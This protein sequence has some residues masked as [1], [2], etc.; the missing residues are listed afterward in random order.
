[1]PCFSDRIPL[2]P[3]CRAGWLD[4]LRM[5]ITWFCN[6]T[7]T[8]GRSGSEPAAGGRTLRIGVAIAISIFNYVVYSGVLLAVPST[9]AR[10]GRGRRLSRRHGASYFGYS[11][12]VFDR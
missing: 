11:R 12:L 8:F 2:G 7:L 9:A 10:R 6:R 1:M 5:T 3:Y 4:R